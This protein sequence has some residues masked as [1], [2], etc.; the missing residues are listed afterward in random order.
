MSPEPSP[1]GA[2]VRAVAAQLVARVLEERV[3][4]D[5]LLPA[6]GVTARDQP[7]LAAL[8]FGA[9]RW[10]LPARM[11]GQAVAH[12]AAR[13][14]PRR[15]RGAAAHRFAA[16][17]GAARPGARSGVCY[18]RCHGSAR[19]TQRA[20]ARERGAAA[21]SARAR[22]A[23]AGR[24]A[25]R[26]GALRAPAWLIDAIRADYPHD[27]QA[28]LDGQQRAAPD[29]AARQ[30][31]AHDPRGLSRQAR[32]GRAGRGRR[33]GRRVRS[34]ASSSRQAWTSLP[35]FA[36]GEV[37]VQDLS[38]QHAAALLELDAGQRVLDACAA[39]GGKTGHILEAMPGRGEIWAVDRDADAARPRAR[40]PRAS[41][42]GGEA[43]GG[44]RDGTGRVVGREAV[45]PDSHRRA[46]QRDR[47]D[48]PP[49]RHQGAAPAGRRR[50]RGR[51][52]GAPAP[53]AV[54]A[55]CARAGASSTRP[56][57]F[58]SGKTTSRSP[59][60]APQSRRSRPRTRV[61]S[62]QL[63]PEEARG[64]GFY[65][66][67]LRKPQVLRMPSGSLSATIAKSETAL[68]LLRSVC[69]AHRFVSSPPRSQLAARPAARHAA[70]A[71]R[72]RRARRSRLLRGSLGHGGAAR[73]RLLPERCRSPID[74]RP[75]RATPCTRACRSA[76]GST[77]KSSTRAAGG[78]TTRMPRCCSRTSSNTTRS[79]SATSCST[80]TAA[81]KLPSGRCSRALEFLGRV[82]RL[83]LIDAAV[84][85]DGRG[86]YVRLR[87][88]LDEEQFPG[89][90]RLLAFWRRD[91]SIASEWYRWP[92]LSE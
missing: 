71:R 55:A 29:V 91:W 64:D 39:P 5:D 2:K 84:I 86:Y 23:R 59:L 68:A 82:E 65:Y 49:S 27:W 42:L 52:P 74:Y 6:A 17:A 36:T 50:A 43:R 58:S 24:A 66:A 7:L 56:A 35:G 88:V 38:A 51:P 80:S 85:D 11:A 81:T 25:S 28:V 37:S 77:S 89:P 33:T 30:F 61:A 21:F 79:A 31:A 8:V 48:P 83:P 60:F 73:R 72:D 92:L 87:A 4:A 16:A 46:V 15:S 12:A 1:A 45:R 44:R 22:A 26:R 10:H 62:L 76:S 19:A 75:R 70:A 78:S 54:A 63:L 67:W 34:C 20:R 41:R 53:G 32:A 18:G 57:R 69:P 9:L 13:A 90:L 14:R 3:P 40:Q 47:R